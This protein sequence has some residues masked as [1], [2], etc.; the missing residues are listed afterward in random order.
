M[1]TLLGTA[2]QIARHNR[3]DK[4]I[5]LQY[6]WVTEYRLWVRCCSRILRLLG[7][8]CDHVN[9]FS[10][11]IPKLTNKMVEGIICRFVPITRFSPILVFTTGKTRVW[12][13]QGSGKTSLWGETWLREN[14]VSHNLVSPTAWF[15]PFPLVFQGAIMMA[16][17][18]GIWLS[19]SAKSTSHYVLIRF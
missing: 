9:L 17:K 12:W 15:F 11:Y 18:M 14:Q 6:H 2:N 4:L 1:A 7:I 8:W 5:F 16:P 19:P 13:K 3:L 10:I